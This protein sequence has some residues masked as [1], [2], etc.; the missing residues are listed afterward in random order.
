MMEAPANL[1]MTSTNKP[2]VMSFFPLQKLKGSR[3]V[4]TPSIQATILEEKSVD[5]ESIDGEHPDGIQGIT[6]EFIVNLARAV[7][8]AQ[9]TDKWCYHCDSP[10]HFIHDC[11]WLMGAK[12]GASLNWKEGMTSRRGA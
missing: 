5:K 6:K 12:V 10:D 1:T 2:K 4:M 9:Q 11:P 8:D 7:N 3:P